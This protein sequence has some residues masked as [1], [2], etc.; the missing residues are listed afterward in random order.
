MKPD[1]AQ[2]Q[3]K[4]GRGRSVIGLHIGISSVNAAQAVYYKGRATL[5]KTAVEKVS[6]KE[7]EDADSV[8][9]SA[10]RTVLSQFSFQ[11][12]AI[13]CTF[14]DPQVFVRKITTPPMPLQ[15]L[16]PAVQ[17]AVKNAFP[18]SLDE[19]VLDFRLVNKFSHQG[20]ER[21]NVLAAACPSKV[22]E[23]IQDLFLIRTIKPVAGSLPETSV[24]K[25][26]FKLGNIKIASCI[27]VA[28]ALENLIG[29]SKSKT[30]ETLAVIALE[31][32]V[33]ELMIYRNSHLEFSRRLSVAAEDITKS[34]TGAFFSDTGKTELTLLE[35]EEIKEEHG[36]PKP[37]EPFQIN[38]K[39]TS[40][41]VLVLIGPKIEQLATEINR[42]FD[43]YR[44]ELQGGKVV[45]VLLVGEASRLKRLDEFLSDQL[46]L[47]VRCGNPLEGIA[48]LDPS[49]IHSDDAAQ[50]QLL[51]IGAALGDVRG[52]NLLSRGLGKKNKREIKLSVLKA[53]TMITAVVIIF[54]F[55][56]LNNQVQ[57]KSKQVNL[58]KQEFTSRLKE[59]RDTLAVGR[60]REGR[61]SWEEILKVF[62]HMPRDIYLNE[63]NLNNDQLHIKGVVLVEGENS[64]TT[65]AR[66]ISSLQENILKDARLKLSK[67]IKDEVNKFEFEIVA[68][69]ETVKQ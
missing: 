22:I 63:L 31:S 41:Q 32:T 8:I 49:L 62:S 66:F 25:R 24:D 13:I 51:A 9:S 38:A 40:Q 6:L 42:S 3:S 27:P 18:F 1:L 61:P 21:Y 7:G 48:L 17:L 26:K 12:A 60:L 68:S 19:A 53:S 47:E 64:K 34:M 29:R 39:I 33:T 5:I 58:K 59:A 36:I 52:I 23:R 14:H 45:R 20:K 43:Y 35:A 46:G 50:Q 4:L 44:E 57:V 55:T 65:L 16:G 15:E 28:I 37:D 56:F 54:V 30:D 2:L 69:V 10:L 11:H 67:K